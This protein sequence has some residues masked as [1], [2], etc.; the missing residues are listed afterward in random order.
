MKKIDFNVRD[1]MKVGLDALSS[2]VGSTLGAKGRNVIFQKGNQYT[3]TKDG[4]TVSKEVIMDDPIENAAVYTVKEAA[5]R[6]AGEAGDGTTTAT[7]IACYIARDAFGLVDSGANPMDVKRGIDIASKLAMEFADKITKKITDDEQL[8]NIA[9]ISANND[10]YIGGIISDIF[11]RVGRTGAVRIE[12]T[13]QTET[14]VDITEGCQLNS[15]WLSPNFMN[16]QSKQSA[17]YSDALIFIT[18]KKFETSFMEIA[19]AL[20]LCAEAEKPLLI[21]CGGMEG[22]PL[23]TLV[24]NKMKSSFPVVAASA[25]EFGDKRIEILDDVAAI[26]GGKMISEARGHKIDE[27]TIDDLGTARKIIVTK[28][29]TT[30]LGRNGNPEEIQKRSESVENQKKEDKHRENTWYLNRRLA[31][32]TGGIGIIYVGS[33]SESETRDLYYRVEDAV[34]ATKAAME[35]GYVAGGGVAY[36]QI[37]EMLEEMIDAEEFKKDIKD[38]FVAVCRSLVVPMDVIAKNAGEQWAYEHAREGLGFN[39][40]N[41][42]WEDMFDA[43]IIDPVKVVK[44]AIKNACSVAGMLVT[45]EC[46]ITDIQK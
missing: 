18:D 19:R 5:S 45:T 23:G 25:P 6:T 8:R 1:K 21:I 15:G 27:M 26:T 34:H 13:Q 33:N 14:T 4:V 10:E 24:F 41:N 20:E 31:T 40:L 32:L 17:E 22:E 28:D 36:Y 7:V 38:G 42:K 16:N 9:T 35:E 39:A 37:S 11:K 3:I 46:V 44:S 43:G 29:F 30:I 12:E 2:S